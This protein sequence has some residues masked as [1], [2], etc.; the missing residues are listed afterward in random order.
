MPADRDPAAD[1]AEDL[2]TVER[3]GDD[4]HESLRGAAGVEHVPRGDYSYADPGDEVVVAGDGQHRPAALG[5]LRSIGGACGRAG[6]HELGQQIVRQSA[7][8]EGV[9]ERDAGG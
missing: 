8:R 2:V 1:A 6:G 9:G 5:Q 3:R 7:P 4:A